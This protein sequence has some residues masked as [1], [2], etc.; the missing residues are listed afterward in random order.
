MF[1]RRPR[2]ALALDSTTPE[3]RRG[4]TLLLPILGPLVL[5]ATLAPIL[6]QQARMA[7]WIILSIQGVAIVGLLGLVVAMVRG[8][9]R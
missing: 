1:L 8:R 3:S 4:S 7:T 5:A 2:S 9:E 6:G